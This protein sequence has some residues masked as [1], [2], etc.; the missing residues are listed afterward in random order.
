MSTVTVS[1]NTEYIIGSAVTGSDGVCGDLRRIIVDPV[2]QTI[3]HLVVEPRHR[4]GEGHLVPIAL[5]DSTAK[6]IQLRCT[7]TEFQGLEDAEDTHVLPEA[8]KAGYTEDQKRWIPAYSGMAGGGGMAG[9]GPAP[10]MGGMGVGGMGAM[11]RGPVRQAIVT[12]DQVPADEIQLCSDQP[13]HATDGAIGRVQGLAV[14][15]SDHHV[16]H[17]LLDEGHLWGKKRVAIPFSA[18]TSVDD[19]VQLNLAKDQVRDLPAIDVPDWA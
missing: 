5:V 11:G 15:P 4:Y 12:E 3:T 7:T 16:T 1:S 13:V 10:A 9:L 8:G 14:D 18:V 6:K 17:V 2:A 19:G